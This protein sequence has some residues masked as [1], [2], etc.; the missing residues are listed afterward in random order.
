MKPLFLILLLSSPCLAVVIT[1]EADDFAA[2]TTI[3][4]AYDYI[5]LSA[6]D[7]SDIY[8]VPSTNIAGELGDN[9]LGFGLNEN[10]PFGPYNDYDYFGEYLIIEIDGFA[11]SISANYAATSDKIINHCVM[12]LGFDSEGT[13]FAIDVGPHIDWRDDGAGVFIQTTIDRPFTQIAIGMIEGWAVSIDNIVI[14]YTSIPEPTTIIL[15]G[16]GAI[17]AFKLR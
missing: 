17:V 1:I 11:T 15:L 7:G 10:W 4:N 2:G 5:T 16:L 6:S 9:V 14:E 3:S 8:S 12:M 13:Q